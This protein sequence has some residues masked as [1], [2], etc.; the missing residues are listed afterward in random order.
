[1]ILPEKAT[2]PTMYFV[3]VTTGKSSIMKVFP[4]WAEALGLE[5]AVLRGIDIAIH[6]DPED[7]RDAVSFIKDDA[8][9]LGALLTT[10]KFD[11]YNAAYDLFDYLDPYA[12]K[13]GEISSISKKDGWLGGYAK[14]PI[15]SGLAMKAFIPEEFFKEHSGH[16]FIMGAGGSALAISSYHRRSGGEGVSIPKGHI[17][18]RRGL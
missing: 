1:M 14:D 2:R 18:L 7:Y 17:A 5:G 12:L 6:A 15:S 10:H 8:L 11:L 13:F 3:G 16:V 4:L 9:S